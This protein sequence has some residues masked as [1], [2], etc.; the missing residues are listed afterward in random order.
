MA[1]LT[2]NIPYFK[3]FVRGEYLRN[4][5]KGHGEYAKAYVHAIRCRRGSSFWF[6]CNLAEPY[7]GVAFRLPI[8]ALTVEPDAPVLDVRDLQPWDCLADTFSVVPLRF[9]AH[10][11]VRIRKQ[12]VYGNYLFSVDFGAEDLPD[13]PEQSK[14][15]HVIARED[16]NIGAYP[17][18]RLEWHDTAYWEVSEQRPD[19]QALN[20]VV[21][22]ESAR[23][24]TRGPD[25]EDTRQTSFD[26]TELNGSRELHDWQG[27]I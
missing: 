9:V 10:Q 22:A 17:N 20:V 3:A 27:T 1:F 24:E 8:T 7:G 14:I 15:L 5:S 18:N 2:D 23:P 25:Q 26:L 19:F 4:L 16:G 13:D 6:Q 11:P 12:N 21:R